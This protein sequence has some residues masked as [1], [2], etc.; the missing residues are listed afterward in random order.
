MGFQVGSFGHGGHVG[1]ELGLKFGGAD[2]LS[3]LMLVALDSGN[4]FG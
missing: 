1:G 4:G 2:V 3:L